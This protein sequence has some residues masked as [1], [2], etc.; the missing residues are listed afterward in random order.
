MAHP[1]HHSRS[2][3]LTHGGAP[4]DYLPLHRFFDS[5]KVSTAD[6]RHRFA[7]HSV[8]YGI[9]RAEARFGTLWNLPTGS[10]AVRDL[11]RQHIE[12]D[13]GFPA[14]LQ[15]WLSLVPVP[16]Q[17]PLTIKQHCRLSARRF[18]GEPSDY[19]PLH[20][21]L[22]GPRAIWDDPRADHATHTAFG[23]FLAEA[24][25]GVTLRR[26]SDGQPVPVRLLA[27]T[28]VLADLDHIPTLH[29]VIAP[30]PRKRWMGHGALP[31]S[32]ILGSA[33][34]LRCA[35]RCTGCPSAA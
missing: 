13:L 33:E 26:A 4:E 34:D 29:H 8:D 15:D 30:M 12:E 31:L 3:A 18:G 20:R 2:S 21:W 22:D 11:S 1:W 28:H 10:V 16:S 5:S 6:T 17:Q 27:E 32:R 9:E 25:L 7:L 24:E 14:R 19:D 23:I 35:E